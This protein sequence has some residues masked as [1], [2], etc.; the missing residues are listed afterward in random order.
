MQELAVRSLLFVPGDNEKMIGKALASQADAVIV[1]LEDAV[2]PENKLKAREVANAV[3]G[4]RDLAAKPVFIRVNAF[5]TGETVHDLAAV[6]GAFPSG[7]MLPKCE[8]MDEVL[9]LSHHIDALEAREGTEIGNTRILTVATETAKATLNLGSPEPDVTGRLWGM[10][11]GSEDLKATL[12]SQS[13]RDEEGQYTFPYQLARSQCLYAASALDVVAIDSGYT[14]FRDS[15]GLAAETR[16]GLRDG[17]TAKAAIHPAQCEIINDIM[18]PTQ[19]QLTWAK[20]VV[21]V[22]KDQAVARIDG[23]MVDLA[24]KRV[25]ERLLARHAA[26]SE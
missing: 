18:T 11:W 9:R 19:D 3:V 16:L 4:A 12:G 21:D 1:D 6:M 10:L 20:Q 8:S 7:I 2:A 25:A 22:L 13:N 14:D 15:D 17:F 24:H 23:G 26:F 5:D